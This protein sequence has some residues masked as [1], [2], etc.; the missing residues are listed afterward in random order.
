MKTYVL[1]LRLLRFLLGHRGSLWLR[2]AE[3]HFRYADK[4]LEEADEYARAIKARGDRAVDRA[5]R[6]SH[7]AA[8]LD[9]LIN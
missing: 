2:A 4:V 8:K 6:M 1:I 3:L 7:A 9:A 5:I